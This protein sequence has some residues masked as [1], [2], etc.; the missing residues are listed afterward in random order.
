M[1][2][3]WLANPAIY[4]HSYLLSPFQRLTS[5]KE[6]S[7]GKGVPTY[8]TLLLL[9]LSVILS[10]LSFAHGITFGR[11]QL[12]RVAISQPSVKISFKIQLV[13]LTVTRGEGGIKGRKRERVIRE[14]VQRTHGH[15]QQD[16]DWL[17]EQEGWAGQGRATGEKLGQLKL[18]NNKKKIQL[19]TVFLLY[20]LSGMNKLIQPDSP[21][22]PQDTLLLWLRNSTSTGKNS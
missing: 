15:G 18:N 14:H 1:T 10:I 6:M 16:G 22:L 7:N 9:R 17:W 12:P 11:S 2:R 5:Q 19:V 4:W 13:K 20:V 3:E 21:W 8:C